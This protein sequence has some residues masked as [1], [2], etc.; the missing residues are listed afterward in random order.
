[1]C[2]FK[3]LII[4]KA[5]MANNHGNENRLPLHLSLPRDQNNNDGGETY[6]NDRVYQAANSRNYPTTPSTFPQ[7][8]YSQQGASQ[9]YNNAQSQNPG[10][11]HS[12]GPVTQY[13]TYHQQAQYQQ[14][15][16]QN[17]YPSRNQNSDP[18]SG[19]AHQFSTQ[20]LGPR[21]V[22]YNRPSPLSGATRA[23]SS[24]T[25]GNNMS[26]SSLQPM[27]SEEKP[28][29]PDPS[30]Y[31]AN[32]TK[33]VVG[34]HL[35]VENFFKENIQRARDRNARYDI[36]SSLQAPSDTNSY[37]PVGKTLNSTAM[38]HETRKSPNMTIK[39]TW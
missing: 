12:A 21:P 7:P 35:Y 34:L 29:E 9:E 11:F 33:R 30:K 2:R 13:P 17:L 22:G 31:S 5:I 20:N 26:S 8:T 24:Q 4:K 14:Y 27:A 28:P 37:S 10:Y 38:I 19:L 1:M 15:Q 32:V 25:Y 18:N 23:P 3:V 39:N 16:Q 6:S 36:H